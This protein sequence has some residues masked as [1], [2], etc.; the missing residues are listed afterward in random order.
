MNRK[1][2]VTGGAGYVGSHLCKRLAA[3]G[4]EPVVFDDLSLGNAWAVKW[5]PLVE[6]DLL[7]ERALAAAFA[8]HRPEAVMHLAAASSVAESVRDPER[9]YRVNLQGTLNLLAAMRR[10][11]VEQVVFSSSASV[12]GVPQRTPIPEGHPLQPINPYGNSKLMAERLLFDLERSHGIAS[13]ALRYFNAAGADLEGE[14]GEQ[15]REE[16]HLIPL[17]L[18]VALG[19]RG[20][21]ELYGRDYRTSDGTCIRDYVHVADIA[22]AHVRALDYLRRGGVGIALNL[23]S[24]SGFSVLQVLETLSE[25]TGRE[26]PLVEKPRR[27]GD[28]DELV[29]DSRAARQILGWQPESSDLATILGSAWRWARA[30]AAAVS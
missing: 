18:D 4:W 13:V 27:A 19:R 11:G 17:A 26:I 2:L 29:S 23:G 3:E 10:A 28:P 21:L 9:Y 12:Y 6:G 1:V 24:D 8:A 25:I 22:A 15:R 14:L 30:Q 16:T 5:G 20:H 7:D